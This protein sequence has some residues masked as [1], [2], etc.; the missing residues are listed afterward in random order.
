MLIA[1]P[2]CALQVSDK[3]IMCPHCGFILRQD[4]PIK[5]RAN[6]KS[7]RRLPNGFGQIC[8]LNR[9][10]LRKPYRAMLTVGKTST[11][12]FITKLLKPEAFFSTYNEAYEALL[13][14]HKNPYDLDDDISVK[15]LYDRWIVEY[16]ETLT[17]ESSQRTITGA[18]AYCS[19]VYDMRA[20]DLRARHIK[21]CMEEGVAI[22]RGEEKRPS[23]GVKARIKS[24]FNLML[25]YGLEYEVVDRNYARTF[26][27]SDD[28]INEVQESRR[29]HLAF[30]VN[31]MRTLWQNLDTVAWV[32]VIL[33]QCYAGWR[34]QELGLIELKDVNIEEWTFIGGMKTAAGKNRVVPIHSSIQPIVEK[35]YRE[36]ASLG[37]KYLINCTDTQTHRS[38][39]LLTYDKYRCRFNKVRDR[40]GLNPEHRAHDG[41]KQFVT[42]AKQHKVD[43]Y[44]I[45]R[46]IGHEIGDLTEEV[47]TERDLAWL[48]EE[49]DKIPNFEL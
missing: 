38:S 43:E 14:Y 31:E 15:E 10:N 1:C 9:K 30:T 23:A 3:A 49:I 33:L 39:L 22:I 41:R 37:S 36:A 40:L 4:A 2:E 47:Y 18:W 20:K 5:V 27:V 28:I 26:D 8:K 12:K 21:G 29:G 25:D 46:I 42:M 6:T 35:K 17:V 45:K 19:S 48:R 32:D 16:F 44:A 34:P 13:E 11:G 7:H 24:L